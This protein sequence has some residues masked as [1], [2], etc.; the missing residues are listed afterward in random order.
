MAGP[1]PDWPAG[2]ADIS[3]LGLEVRFAPANAI[4]RFLSE[5]TGTPASLTVRIVDYPGEWLLDIPLLEQ[6]YTQWSAATLPMFRTGARSEVAGGTIALG[7]VRAADGSFP[8]ELV[9]GAA[10][11]TV[12]P[13]P[14]YDPEGARLRA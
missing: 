13:T 11:A 2:T 5:I 12:V 6:S 9:A 4:G 3:E 7:W 14:F 8:T 10:R 1:L